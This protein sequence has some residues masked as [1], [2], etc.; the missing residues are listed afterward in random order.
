MIK[1]WYFPSQNIYC[2][3]CSFHLLQV[4]A[5]NLEELEIISSFKS[6]QRLVHATFFSGNQGG[7]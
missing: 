7:G 3:S 5:L 6:M 2:D 1:S 4:Q